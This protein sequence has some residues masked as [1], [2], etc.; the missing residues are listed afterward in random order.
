MKSLGMSRFHGIV[1]VDRT[2]EVAG[3]SP[4]S[5]TF[6]DSVSANIGVLPVA[7]VAA[8]DLGLISRS[9]ADQLASAT[10]GEVGRLKRYD[11]FLYQWC[12]TNTGNILGNP[13][14][15]DCTET[16]PSQGNCWF[17]S[18]VDNGWYATGLIEVR[19]ALPALRGLAD[20]LLAPMARLYLS[21]ERMLIP[22]ARGRTRLGAGCGRRAGGLEWIERC[23]SWDMSSSASRSL[24]LCCWSVRRRLRA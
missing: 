12:D 4:A 15:G 19:Q 8:H 21:T 11:G 13:G 7:V 10:L 6:S 22:Q 18:G 16:T 2:Q 17:V 3:S 24:A 5:S 1:T 14:Q 20:S 9:R 23:T